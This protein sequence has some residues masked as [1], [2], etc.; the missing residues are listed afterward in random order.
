MTPFLG[1]GI[2]MLHY[3]SY[4]D[5]K[6]A[7]GE[8]YYYWQDGSIRNQPQNGPI[9][10][11]TLQTLHRD[12][13]YE[14]R[15]DSLNK[16][17]HHPIYFPLTFGIEFKIGAAAKASLA[18]TYYYTLSNSIDG[19]GYGNNQ[20]YLYTNF[21]ICLQFGKKSEQAKDTQFDN[22]DFSK[23]DN[24]DTDGDGVFDIN[25]ECPGTPNGVKVDAKGC[26]IDSDGDGIPDYLDKEPHSASGALVD[27]QGVTLT[28]EVLAKKK[29]D[30]EEAL[31]HV[32]I[33]QKEKTLNVSGAGK[34][35]P[36]DLKGADLNGD[37]LIQADEITKIIDGF[38]SGE[39]DFTVDKINR[40]IDYFFEQ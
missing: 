24:A 9:N 25:D 16:F 1:A 6:D 30:W 31:T 33:E 35:I 12:Y 39:N 5:L 40:L 21:S 19:T 28:A 38:F 2:G 14:T 32:T 17:N 37:G 8:T 4:A 18:A 15:I 20:G 11:A 3:D 7:N 36:D 10:Y 13:V 26:P 29:K 23:I 22:V 34:T 27:N